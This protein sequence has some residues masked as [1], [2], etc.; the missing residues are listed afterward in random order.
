MRF[1]LLHGAD[2]RIPNGEPPPPPPGIPGNPTG[3]PPGGGVYG[4]DDGGL[5]GGDDGGDRGGTLGGVYGGD[6]GGLD[7]GL[8]GVRLG[9]DRGGVDIDEPGEKGILGSW[10]P[11]D[12]PGG[13]DLGDL[14][15]CEPGDGRGDTD[16]GDPTGDLKDAP[17]VPFDD[18]GNADP[19]TPPD[20]TITLLIIG[21]FDTIPYPDTP[22]VDGVARSTTSP[23]IPLLYGLFLG[24]M[25]GRSFGIPPSFRAFNIAVS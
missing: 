22:L 19:H 2:T 24:S 16:E 21:M 1:F 6:D 15:G 7:G 23:N 18:I 25:P 20:P 10:I 4:G 14:D 3:G 11:G 13:G 17:D 12:I 8:P 9:G 5:L